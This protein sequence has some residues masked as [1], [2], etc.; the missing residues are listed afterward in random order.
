MSEGIGVRNPEEDENSLLTRQTSCLIARHELTKCHA[1]PHKASGTS[2]SASG[3]THI[4]R[5]ASIK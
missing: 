4:R 5:E 3:D 1:E 2:A